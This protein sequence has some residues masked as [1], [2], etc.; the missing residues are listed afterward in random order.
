MEQQVQPSSLASASER[1][2]RP[3]LASCL[4]RRQIVNVTTLEQ[5][6]RVSDVIFDSARSQLVGVR[7]QPSAPPQGLA[8]SV[9]RAFGRNRGAVAIALDHII[10]L[11]GDVVMVDADPARLASVRSLTNMSHLNEVCEL[12]I[13]TTFGMC[14][15]ALADVLVD[16]RGLAILGYV[17]KPTEVAEQFLSPLESFQRP[18][19][20]LL[21]A[22]MDAHTTETLPAVIPPSSHL[23]IIPASSRV[24][25]GDS[26]ILFVAEVEPLEPQVVVIAPRAEE[27]GV[28][29]RNHWIAE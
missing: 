7:V 19:I 12:A 9:G 29:E 24:R 1:S 21:D 8:A 22:D 18:E 15:G 20:E 17:V 6:G 5:V 3:W 27:P 11:N 26:L 4:L 13:L 10:A 16:A 25:F 2:E 23:R 14:L 28:I